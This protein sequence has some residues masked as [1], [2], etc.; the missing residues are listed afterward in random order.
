MENVRPELQDFREVISSAVN[1]RCLK[2]CIIAK[3]AIVLA[4]A[5]SLVAGESLASAHD[6][7]A[8]KFGRCVLG[9]EV[10]VRCQTASD[11]THEDVVNIADPQ[12]Q[13]AE[14]AR[15]I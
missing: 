12:D 10:K 13:I 7:F 14:L 6:K 15:I 8:A 11:C 9:P 1:E 3:A 2:E 5:N 4:S